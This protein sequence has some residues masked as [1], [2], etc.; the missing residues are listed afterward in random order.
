MAYRDPFFWRRC[1]RAFLLF[2]AATSGASTGGCGGDSKPGVAVATAPASLKFCNS[3]GGDVE[4]RVGAV[5]IKA[6]A[7]QCAPAISLPCLEIPS[8]AQTITLSTGGATVYSQQFSIEPGAFY[9]TRAMNDAAG[10]PTLSATTLPNGGACAADNPL[11]GTINPG[12][13]DAGVPDAA[14]P[15]PAA[16][17]AGKFCHDLK[18]TSMP[19]LDLELV[20]GTV[21]LKASTNGCSSP[22]NQACGGLPVGTSKAE[23]FQGGKSIASATVTLQANREYVIDLDLDANKQVVITANP[24]KPEFKCATLDPYAGSAPPPP[25]PPGSTTPGK[26]CHSLNTASMP[27]VELEL[28][29]GGTLH[30]KATTAGCS[31]PLP[32]ACGGLPVGASSVEVFQGPK[33][34]ATGMV[35]IDANK[36][37]IIDLSLDANK[38]IVINANPLKPEFKCATLDPYAMTMPPPPPPPPAATAQFRLCTVVE[39]VPDGAEGEVTVG[40]QTFKAVNKTCMPAQ[41]TACAALP[42]GPATFTAK[43]MGMPLPP[44]TITIPAAGEL[45]GAFI[46]DKTTMK[47]TFLVSKVPAGKTCAT[48]P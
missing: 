25:P 40:T 22:V 9:S 45:V 17:T 41:G 44:L 12:Q 18:T 24:L 26:F 14:P 28:V 16:T 5:V 8:G 38:Q 13:P 34:I 4:L 42:A 27:Q 48:Y 11:G 3:L 32:M 31:T 21:H 19:S 36:E 47:P 15:P 35:M 46:T 6:P 23:V 7:D 39:N 1:T 2:I 37:Y 10:K 33:S 20:V 30:L 29:V 43:F